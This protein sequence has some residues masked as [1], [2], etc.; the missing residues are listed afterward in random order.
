MCLPTNLQAG[1][2]QSCATLKLA[3]IGN[4]DQVNAAATTAQAA[5]GG[6]EWLYFLGA[7]EDEGG[8]L[9]GTQWCQTMHVFF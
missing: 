1:T 3:T 8:F 4:R 9:G 6:C 2:F 5:G 7:K